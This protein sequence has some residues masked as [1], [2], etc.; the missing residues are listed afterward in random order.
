MCRGVGILLFLVLMLL[1][2]V[3][4]I[5]GLLIVVGALGG[6]RGL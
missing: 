6:L 5:P 3:N 4:V 2:E 1:G